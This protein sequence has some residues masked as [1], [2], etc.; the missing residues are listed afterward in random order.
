MAY[1]AGYN[2]AN[3]ETVDK[4]TEKD[5][6]ITKAIVE[7]FD[8][9]NER[10]LRE[11]QNKCMETTGNFAKDMVRAISQRY[12][13]PQLHDIML[14]SFF[15]PQ[16]QL[17]L[18]KWAVSKRIS[19]REVAEHEYNIKRRVVDLVKSLSPIEDEL[20][21]LPQSTSGPN[22]VSSTTDRMTGTALQQP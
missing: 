13:Y 20:S 3:W 21:K 10:K 5:Q 1:I 18:P 17:Q 12:T 4:L 15:D 16:W 7:Q 22:G 19:G 11:L 9:S 14:I 6:K 8:S 2:E